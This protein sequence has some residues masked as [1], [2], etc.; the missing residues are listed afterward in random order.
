MPCHSWVKKP[1]SALDKSL[2]LS[3]GDALKAL[4]KSIGHAVSLKLTELPADLG[5]L[6]A[7]VG[8]KQ[9]LSQTLSFGGRTSNLE[10]IGAL[11][12]PI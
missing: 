10:P 4:G 5:E 1:I 12:N 7:A 3:W 8:L 6:G 9:E 2:T 11:V